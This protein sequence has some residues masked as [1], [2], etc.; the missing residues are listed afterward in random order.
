MEIIKKSIVKMSHLECVF[1]QK[2]KFFIVL[3]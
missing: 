1:S 2:N 3:K